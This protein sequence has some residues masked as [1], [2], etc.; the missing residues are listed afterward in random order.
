MLLA[1]LTDFHVVPMDSEKGQI[2]RTPTFLE[3]ALVHVAE[4]DPEVDAILATG[5]LVDSG[6]REEYELL[7]TLLE[8][9]TKPIYM[10]PGNHD[11]RDQMR[12]VLRGQGHSYLP[13]KGFLHY[14]VDLGPLRL[15][16][17][18]TLVPG[19]P[20]GLLCEERLHWLDE[21]LREDN[22]ATLIMQHHPP[23]ETGLSQMDGMG[24]EGSAEEAEIL[25][26]YSHVERIICGHIHRG[27][28]RRFGGTIASTAPSTAHAVELDLRIPG[29]LAVVQEPPGCALHLWRDD[30]LVSHQSFIGDFGPPYVIHERPQ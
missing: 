24:L 8:N 21:R 14:C 22:K 4:M 18:D 17:L 13:E 16:A 9:C 29:R 23:F 7:A 26:K 2:M 28:V 30:A 12:E 27:I 5:D 1:Q 19:E 6:E 3:A 20:G 11:D 15:I 10:I 25:G